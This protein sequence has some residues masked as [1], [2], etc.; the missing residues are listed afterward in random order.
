MPMRSSATRCPKCGNP[1][2]SQST[3]RMQEITEEAAEAD[4]PIIMMEILSS[5]E[6]M[7]I[8]SDLNKINNEDWEFCECAPRPWAINQ[9][10]WWE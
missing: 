1:S 7:G 8:I 6:F 2:L 3:H 4:D 10:M 5:P 9:G